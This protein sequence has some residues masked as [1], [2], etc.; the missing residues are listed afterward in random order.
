MVSQEEEI[1]AMSEAVCQAVSAAQ[2][3]RGRTGR[4]L[5]VGKRSTRAHRLRQIWSPC[6]TA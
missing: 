2:W 3:Q 1:A 5:G 4:L 6:V